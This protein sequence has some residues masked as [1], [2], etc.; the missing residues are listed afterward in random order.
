MLKSMFT[1]IYKTIFIHDVLS[2]LY[3]IV[4][5][6]LHITHNVSN[7]YTVEFLDYVRLPR[8]YPLIKCNSP[9][10]YFHFSLPL[11]KANPRQTCLCH[12]AL[13]PSQ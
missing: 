6:Y 7:T 11:A 10:L 3:Y 9:I 2:Y 12:P 13:S 1:S 8:T 5:I 4:C